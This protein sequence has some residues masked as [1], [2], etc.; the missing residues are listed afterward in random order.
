MDMCEIYLYMHVYVKNTYINA[1]AL[2][3]VVYKYDADGA[4]MMVWK[5]LV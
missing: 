3:H 5:L 2:L 1:S 4:V